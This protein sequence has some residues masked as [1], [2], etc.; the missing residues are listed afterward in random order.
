MKR[1]RGPGGEPETKGKDRPPRR[2]T[3]SGFGTAL[4]IYGATWLVVGLS[5]SNLHTLLTRAVVLALLG[6]GAA[7]VI[8]GRT[9]RPALARTSDRI[10]PGEIITLVA[11]VIALIASSLPFLDPPGDSRD[12]A[13]YDLVPLLPCQERGDTLPTVGDPGDSA[14]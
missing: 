5:T 6:A 4:L 10:G 14:S 13:G 7:F 2:I 3:V 8:V 12:P 11:A 1:R 9:R